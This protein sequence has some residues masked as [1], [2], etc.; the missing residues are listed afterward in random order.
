M[1]REEKIKVWEDSLNAM[2]EWWEDDD[3]SVLLEKDIDSIAVSNPITQIEVVNQDCIDVVKDLLY[4]CYRPCLLN[5]ASA[6][7]PGGGVL[8]GATAQEEEI[9][10]RSDLFLSLV[11]Y[12][13]LA[14]KF[15]VIP[16]EQIYGH[17][18]GWIIYSPGVVFFKDK[19]YRPI[20]DF[21]CD[22]ISCAAPNRNQ[23]E[24]KNGWE[25]ETKRRMRNIFRA[26]Y[27]N[28][29]DSLV[30]GAWGCGVFKNPPE[31]IAKWWHEIIFESEFR[32][33]F[34][35]IVFAVL[36]DKNSVSNN[37]KVF[38]KEFDGN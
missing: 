30:L 2:N 27:I 34:K 25:N 3:S 1:T 4:E 13:N 18:T 10:R 5:F 38:K 22:V 31:E 8:T 24:S 7:Q 37:Y 16:K 23:P 20:L 9:C 17:N 32:D 15:N 11:G 12:S 21:S 33:R 29:R 35:K 28:D 36:N 26:A 14:E 6:K 19:K